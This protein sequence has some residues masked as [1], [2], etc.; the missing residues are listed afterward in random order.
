MRERRTSATGL[1][2]VLASSGRASARKSSSPMRTVAMSCAPMTGA[3]TS[4]DSSG[5]VDAR[6]RS[7]APKAISLKVSRLICSANLSSRKKPT[8]SRPSTSGS[9]SRSIR[10]GT[11]TTCST[12]R[13]CGMKVEISS[14]DFGSLSAAGTVSS[15]A[16]SPDRPSSSPRRPV[17]SSTSPFIWL[18]YS[19]A[20]GCT[21]GGSPVS[22]AAFSFGRSATS[23]ARRVKVSVRP[24]RF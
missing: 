20:S 21:V 19:S 12:P 13:E 8:V 22:T 3:S 10:I 15:S 18:R 11:L 5:S 14:I 7:P 9:G 16:P 2:G 1:P 24:T 23:R 17:S 4:R 6:M